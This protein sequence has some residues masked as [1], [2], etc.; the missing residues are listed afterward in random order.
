[1]AGIETVF[2]TA[3]YIEAGLLGAIGL[4]FLVRVLA[5][6]R[7]RRVCAVAAVTFLLFGV[8]DIVEVETGAWWRPWWLLGWKAACVLSMLPL[9]LKYRRGDFRDAA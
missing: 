4:F 9:F 7:L 1:L 8:S 5:R 6:Q 2:Q 3:N